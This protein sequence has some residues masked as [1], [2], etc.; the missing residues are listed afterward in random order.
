MRRD[1]D[2]YFTDD[3]RKLFD[4]GLCTELTGYGL[5]H[6]T[7][8]GKPAREAWILCDEHVAGL[9]IDVP[10]ALGGMEPL[11]RETYASGEES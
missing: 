4:K 5:P 6:M 3:E 11:F 7:W 9:L 2:D 1:P 8:C 10:G